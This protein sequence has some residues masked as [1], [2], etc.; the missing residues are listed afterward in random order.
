MDNGPQRRDNEQRRMANDKD[1]ANDSAD[2]NENDNGDGNG[3]GNDND[4]ESAQR[5]MRCPITM[6][7]ASSDC[8]LPTADWRLRICGFRITQNTWPQLEAEVNVNTC[9]TGQRTVNERKTVRGR[10]RESK[11][12]R[13]REKKN[14]EQ[15]TVAVII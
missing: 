5:I 9:A 8:R 4:N 15:A 2:D 6:T 10:E 7:I 13:G 11:R 3:N 12:G 1:N 14:T